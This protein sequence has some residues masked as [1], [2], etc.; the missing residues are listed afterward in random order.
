MLVEGNVY[1]QSEIVK[2]G[3]KGLLIKY[4][5]TNESA[6]LA[7][8]FSELVYKTGS[9]NNAYDTILSDC[10][11]YS[12]LLIYLQNHKGY[13]APRWNKYF[14]GK[15]Y[16]SEFLVNV[17]FNATHYNKEFVDTDYGVAIKT[18]SSGTDYYITSDS[19][20]YDEWNIW[21]DYCDDWDF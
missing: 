10:T 2:H 16:D 18:R 11:K 8:E 13:V 20:V 19:S 17:D 4:K 6:K 1:T 9:T 7:R 5:M 3:S 14:Y 15:N 12:H 21:K